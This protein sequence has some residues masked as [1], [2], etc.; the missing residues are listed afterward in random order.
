MTERSPQSE[1]FDLSQSRSPGTGQLLKIVVH[2]SIAPDRTVAWRM[3]VDSDLRV[4]AGVVWL[5]RMGCLDD[6]WLQ[7]GDLI[8]LERHDRIWLGTDRGE[9]ADVTLTSHHVQR[10]AP[11]RRWLSRFQAWVAGAGGF[12]LGI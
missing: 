4:Q 5:T 8:R 10:A 1:S 6:Y 11:L 9:P 7:P 3:S 12:P 2:A